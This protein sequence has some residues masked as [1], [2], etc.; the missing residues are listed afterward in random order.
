[1]VKC[2]KKK[3]KGFCFVFL[4]FHRETEICKDIKMFMLCPSIRFFLWC[5]IFTAADLKKTNWNGNV[6]KHRLQFEATAPSGCGSFVS[7]G[8]FLD[9]GWLVLL[10][11]EMLIMYIEQEEAGR[12]IFIPSVVLSVD[13]VIV[14]LV[15]HT[16][17]DNH[18]G[19]FNF[20]P[21]EPRLQQIMT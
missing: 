5:L 14:V 8:L 4:S 11:G 2:S 1:M 18:V 12:R 21:L 7:V 15:K 19:E 17:R 3:K 6:R 13:V 16:E 20:P 10:R 9:A